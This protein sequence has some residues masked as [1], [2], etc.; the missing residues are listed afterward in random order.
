ME[1]KGQHIK[2]VI[3]S[4]KIKRG[5]SPIKSLSILQKIIEKIGLTVC[6]NTINKMSPGFDIL[7]GLRE[8]HLSFSYWGEYQYCRMSLSSC[9]DF[10]ENVVVEELKK[11]CYGIKG[12]I[13]VIIVTDKSIKEELEGL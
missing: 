4:F 1:L 6:S 7:I 2:E 9:K 12:D 3:F 8:S 13:K 10:D 5:A 11:W